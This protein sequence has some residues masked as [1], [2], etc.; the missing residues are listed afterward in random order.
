MSQSIETSF[1]ASANKLPPYDV[2]LQ[3]DA[4]AEVASNELHSMQKT[5][6]RKNHFSGKP[7]KARQL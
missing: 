1:P 5:L 2:S 3:P 7:E 6:S 4:M